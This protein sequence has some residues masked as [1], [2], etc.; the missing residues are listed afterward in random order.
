MCWSR[1]KKVLFIKYEDLVINPFWEFRKICKWL[2]VAIGDKVLK[3]FVDF[4]DYNRMKKRDKIPSY[5]KG[6]MNVK[7]WKAILGNQLLTIIKIK[8]GNTMRKYNYL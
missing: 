1:Q 8:Y 2:N 5:W 7:N 4:F 6:R 3:K